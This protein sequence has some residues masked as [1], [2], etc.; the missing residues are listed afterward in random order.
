QTVLALAG[1]VETPGASVSVKVA[2]L[3]E[4][5]A[6]AMARAK[7][8]LAVVLLLAAGIAVA[9]T[10]MLAHEVLAAKQPVAEQQGPRQPPV[11]DA[12]RTQPEDQKAV[13]TDQYGDPLPDGTLARMGTVQL[14]HERLATAA[15]SPDGKMIATV[16]SNSLRLWDARTGKLIREIK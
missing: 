3:A 6:K 15:F 13:R 11:G 16:G 1:G 7:V 9:G 10:G 4:E 2:A 14:R 12:R 8:K 5:G